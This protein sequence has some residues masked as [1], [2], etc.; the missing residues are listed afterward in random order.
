MGR[1]W[2]VVDLL[3]TLSLCSIPRQSS[4]P[5]VRTESVDSK[6]SGHNVSQPQHSLSSFVTCSL[7]NII[8]V[9][10]NFPFGLSENGG[11]LAVRKLPPEALTIPG[12]D[13]LLWYPAK[14]FSSASQP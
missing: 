1:V 7:L 13:L 11:M 12:S 5:S 8:G 9:S 4:E 3:S 14:S 6:I 10:Y 2:L